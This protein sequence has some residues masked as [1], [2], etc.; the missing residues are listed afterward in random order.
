VHSFE[1]TD[2]TPDQFVV[3]VNRSLDDHDLSNRVSVRCVGDEI[4]ARISWLGTTEL[5]YRLQES[6]GGF[7]A[8]LQRQRVAPLHGAFQHKF[9]ERFEA[10]LAKVG[11]RLI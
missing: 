6:A 1:V 11:A 5:R 4:V 8:H 9:E 7:S 2:T 10:I 3:Q